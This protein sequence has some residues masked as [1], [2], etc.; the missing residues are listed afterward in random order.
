MKSLLMAE[1]PKRLFGNTGSGRSL[2]YLRTQCPSA[3]TENTG[4]SAGQACLAGHDEKAGNGLGQVYGRLLIARLDSSQRKALR[5]G[6]REGGTNRLRAR[7]SG[8]SLYN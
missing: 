2:C 5:P 1:A 8:N 7:K 6:L 3:A 4:A